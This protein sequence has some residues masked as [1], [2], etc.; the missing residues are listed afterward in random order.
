MKTGK[1]M[2]SGVRTMLSRD[3]MRK[4][5]AGSG[6]GTIGQHCGGPYDPSCG[7]N[8][9]CSGSLGFNDGGVWGP[10]GQWSCQNFV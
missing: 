2:L 1:F 6:C 8:C 10:V 3:E 5:R 7:S 4:I 9:Q